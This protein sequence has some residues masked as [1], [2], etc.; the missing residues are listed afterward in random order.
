MIGAIIVHV[1]SLNRRLINLDGKHTLSD[2]DKAILI[3]TILKLRDI[4]EK[5]KEN[6]SAA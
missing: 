2:E 4:V 5:Q 3:D 1:L 6:D